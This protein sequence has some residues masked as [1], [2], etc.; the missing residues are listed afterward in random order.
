MLSVLLS[1][2]ASIGSTKAYADETTWLASHTLIGK[3]GTTCSIGGGEEGRKES[4][5]AAL[6]APIVASLAKSGINAIGSAFKR[7]GEEKERI[8]T[9]PMSPITLASIK[10]LVTNTLD[11]TQSLEVEYTQ[12]CVRLVVAEVSHSTLGLVDHSIDPSKLGDLS[13]I[14][15]EVKKYLKGQILEE[16][17]KVH[18]YGEY[19]VT[20][21]KSSAGESLYQ[22]APK[23]IWYNEPIS[24]SRYTLTGINLKLIAPSSGDKED[25]RLA[26]L[27]SFAPKGLKAGNFRSS[28]LSSMPNSGYLPAPVFSN[29]ET[30]AIETL[31]QELTTYNEFIR[32]SPASTMTAYKTAN[33]DRGK[34]R[35]ERIELERKLCRTKNKDPNDARLC[36]V[37]LEIKIKDSTLSKIESGPNNNLRL[38]RINEAITDFPLAYYNAQFEVTESRAA[39][40]FYLAVAKALEDTAEDRGTIIDS[41]V[42]EKFG[43]VQEVSTTVNEGEY[44][45]ALFDYNEALEGLNQARQGNDTNA[46]STAQ[47]LAIQRFNDLRIASEQAGKAFTGTPPYP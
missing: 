26:Y 21:A 38:G 2:C 7:A 23:F 40:T 44:L 19:L 30:K 20:P 4:L 10:P 27:H 16:I 29:A 39:N 41:F 14:E 5:I 46:T 28:T 35:N 42:Q 31:Q 45:L 1:S 33:A 9:T 8:H 3:A 47:R 13:S 24:G 17:H 34:L 32:I 36:E 22:V 11:K 43:L 18:L 37:N 25:V 15:E 6:A 12:R